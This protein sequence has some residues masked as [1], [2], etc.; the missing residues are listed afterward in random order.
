MC[1]CVW[2][3]EEE[4]R[5]EFQRTESAGEMFCS[6]MTWKARDFPFCQMERTP[7]SWRQA[8]EGSGPELLP[9]RLGIGSFLESNME[10]Q[11][12]GP[13]LDLAWPG[14]AWHGTREYPQGLKHLGKAPPAIQRLAGSPR[15]SRDRI[16]AMGCSMCLCCAASTLDRKLHV[17][18]GEQVV[19]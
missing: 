2:P 5:R 10:S 18:E 17:F 12:A 4:E 9:P 13:G 3:E 14:L 8:P 19:E 7:G 11:P 15:A 16:E 6:V 1:V